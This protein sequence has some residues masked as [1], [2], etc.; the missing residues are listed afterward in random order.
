[1]R[2]GPV[3]V[4]PRGEALAEHLE[5]DDQVGDELRRALPRAD[6]AGEAPRQELRIVLDI[7][8]QVE[9]LLRRVR[10]GAA[11][12]RGSASAGVS[13]PAQ[14]RAVR[15]ACAR[16]RN[17]DRRDRTSGSAATTPPARTPWRA[18]WSR[19]PRTPSGVTKRSMPA[20]F[21]VGCR[22]WPMVR[23]STPAERRSSITCS[24]SSR[25]LAEA[26]H[27]AGLGEQAGSSLLGAVQQAQRVV[28]ARAGP[29]VGVEPRH[30]LEV[31]VEDVRAG[32]D[33]RFQR[34]VLVAEVGGQHLD[35]GGRRGGA[36]RSMQRTNCAA[37]PSARSSRSTEVI[38]TCF[39]PS[40]PTVLGELLRLM[41]ID[42]ARLAGGD[43]AEG[44]GARADIA[45]DHEGGVLARPALADVGAR[46]LLADGVQLV[47]ADQPDGLAVAGEVGAFTRIHAG[48]RGDGLSGRWAFSGWRAAG[49][50]LIQAIW[51]TLAA[52]SSNRAGGGKRPC[53]LKGYF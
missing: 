33:H 26:D 49:S 10:D 12:R 7:G 18:R 34:A 32:G 50:T 46:R 9:H 37:P 53:G 16:R 30:R 13:S 5:A 48:L 25:A 4:D 42:R 20:C 21:G 40:L 3:D 6:A 22:Y 17:R 29:D 31:V 44:A 45:Q 38:T 14:A 43:V 23:K 41:R 11:S 47:L 52:P 24:T 39:R 15:R 35:G 2:L 28:V 51:Q 8:D 27:D 1:M 36:D 19:T